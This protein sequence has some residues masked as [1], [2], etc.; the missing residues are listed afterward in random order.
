VNCAELRERVL[1][2]GTDEQILKWCFERGRQLN[3]GDLVVWNN[4]ISKLGWNDFA[5]P[6][7]EKTKL[8]HGLEHRTDIV[9]IPDLIDLDEGRLS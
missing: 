3:K 7:L 4:F 8:E 2:G 6:L 1:T 5:T 9:T